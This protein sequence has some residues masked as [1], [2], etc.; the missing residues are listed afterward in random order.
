MSNRV[1][2][3]EQIARFWDDGYLLVKGVLS[4]RET[5]TARRA[6]LDLLPHDL[7]IPDYYASHGGRI[8]PHHPDR[9]HSYFTPELLP[10]L[11]NETLYGVA[12][13][14]LETDYLGVGDGSVG[15]TIKDSSGPV[16]SQ[17]IH[18]DMHKPAEFNEWTLRYKVGIGGCYYLTKVEEN[19]AGI[20]VIPGAPKRITE[21]LLNRPSNEPAELPKSFDDFPPTVEVL[22]DAGDFVLMHHLMPHAASRNRRATARVVQFTRYRHLD[23]EEATRATRSDEEWTPEQ[24]AALTPLGRKLFGFDPWIPSS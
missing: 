16:L 5:Q 10:L 17:G 24:H 19:G 21:M 3:D 15:I 8:K 4:E 23:I 2:S 12:A 14:L 1:L 22:G 20:H 11:I 18:L 7:T 9:N 6:I 13:D